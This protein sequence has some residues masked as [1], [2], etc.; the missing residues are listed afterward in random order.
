MIMKRQQKIFV[1]VAV[2]IMVS[3]LLVGPLSAGPRDEVSRERQSPP[4]RI[5]IL[6]PDGSP[7]S[8][9][10]VTGEDMHVSQLKMGPDGYLW[11]ARAD[12]S[13]SSGQ[14][15][16]NDMVAVFDLDGHEIRTISGGGMR[17]PR[18]IGW[19]NDGYIYVPAE[20][21]YF[22]SDIYK[23]EPNGT[24][25][26]KFHTVGWPLIDDYNDIVTTQEERLY[27]SAWHGTGN[28]DQ[29]TEFDTAGQTVNTFSPTGPS[30]FHRDITLSRSSTFWVRTPRNGS[31][32]DLV[33]EFDY[34]GSQIDV[35]SSSAG[36]PG[37][38]MRGLEIDRTG[39]GTLHML[40]VNDQTLY[41]FDPDGNVVSLTPLQSLSGWIT[42]F[43]FGPDQV[44]L[45]ANQGEEFSAAGEATPGGAGL[46]LIASPNPCGSRLHLRFDTRAV[47]PGALSILDV[48]GRP[49]RIY[50]LST[51][52]GTLTWD[53]A[54]ASGCPLMT[55]TYFVRLVA[56]QERTTR[57]VLLI[58]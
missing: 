5:S 34:A 47:G 29:M 44:I 17:H 3:T 55:G 35:F 1:S 23:Y 50:N 31:G 19:D 26:T 12:N 14:P 2:L 38:N 51:P 42:D 46:V 28:V 58:R 45:V 40:N 52:S 43:T 27:A 13:H 7:L 10:V 56:G 33:R 41:E 36:A 21:I 15:N 30:Y 37:S 20:D 9:F 22:A 49:V 53:G 32:D 54:D 11:I 39:A 4:F 48:A 24:Y 16:P 18:S 57:R 6:A 8:E 25:V